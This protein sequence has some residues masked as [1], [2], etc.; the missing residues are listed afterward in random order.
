MKRAIIPVETKAIKRE[1]SLELE[2]ELQEPGIV[3]DVIAKVKP[4]ALEGGEPE[5]VPIFMVEIDPD[6]EKHTRK[7]IIGPIMRQM[8]V[9]D[10][11]AL[12]YVGKLF[13]L[14]RMFAVF[15]ETSRLPGL[16][17]GG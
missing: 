3:R 10:Y 8:E 2:L 16:L 15:E 4:P 12:T 7:F 17:S 14:D 11:S 9:D 6:G 13:M 5:V 1:E